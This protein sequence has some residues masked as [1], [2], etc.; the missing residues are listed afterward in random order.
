[1]IT[2][3][4]VRTDEQAK[5]TEVMAWE[6]VDW[7]KE[8]YPESLREIDDYME[9]QEFAKRMAD[10]RVD[11][12]PPSGESLIAG[13][14]GAPVGILMMHGIS[15]TTCEMNRM[16]VRPAARGNGVARLLAEQLIEAARRMG[17]KR[18][19]LGALSRHHEALP[20]YRSLGFVEDDRVAFPGQTTSKIAMSLDLTARGR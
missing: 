16:F 7:L 14:D 8:R 3:E 2:I 18:M 15:D 12:A 4:P 11:Y 20:L 9:R 13:L 1:M 5:V 6:F 10:V 19:T 17:F